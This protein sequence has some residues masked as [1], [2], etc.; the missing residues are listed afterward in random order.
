MRDGQVLISTHN[1]LG[2]GRY[3]DVES[4]VSF[5]FDHVTQVRGSERVRVCVGPCPA[6]R[7]GVLFW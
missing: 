6:G 1:S 4:R 3:Y 2:N 7:M 5:A